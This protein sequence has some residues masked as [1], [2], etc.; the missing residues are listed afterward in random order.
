MNISSNIARSTL[1]Q[2]VIFLIGLAGVLFWQ[3]GN[4]ADLYLSGDIN[5]VGWM[6]NAVI[7]L[8]FLLGLFRIIALLLHYSR[9]HVVLAGFQEALAHGE[10]DPIARLPGDSLSVE[11]YQQIQDTARI[12]APV[13]QG[14]MAASLNTSEQSRFTLVRYVNSILIL[15]GVFGTVVSLSIA[16]VGASNLLDSPEATNRMGMIIG[17]MSSALSTTMTAI[18]CYVFYAYFYLRLTNA[19][20]QLLNGIESVTTQY[21]MPS[22]TPTEGT[23]MRQVSELTAVLNRSSDRLQEMQQN[24]MV[25]A[26][27]LNAAVQKQTSSGG[28][29]EASLQELK[30]LLREG[31]RLPPETAAP[32]PRAAVKSQ[33]TLLNP[34]QRS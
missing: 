34:E 14:A 28:I 4:I 29:S 9:E 24:F 31:F 11:R 26:E 7:I 13:N 23:I 15:L 10:A 25:A 2:V 30:A 17:G 22:V 20:A 12:F 19:R 5:P 33:S 3:R 32:A 8:L 18:V 16:L 27:Q 6:L 1:F 21:L